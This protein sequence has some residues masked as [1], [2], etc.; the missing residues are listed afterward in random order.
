MSQLRRIRCPRPDFTAS[1][2]AGLPLGRDAPSFNPAVEVFQTGNCYT[3]A[4]AHKGKKR[5]P[6]QMKSRDAWDYDHFLTLDLAQLTPREYLG[7]IVPEFDKHVRAGARHDGLIEIGVNPALSEIPRG[8]NLVALEIV[9]GDGQG[10][11]KLDYHWSRQDSNGLFSGKDGQW[12]WVTNVDHAGTPVTDPRNA[13]WR[14]NVKFSSF[15][16]VPKR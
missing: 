7:S 5:N 12:G 16:L 15:F 2:H 6:G 9:Y 4:L 3:Y 11:R 13:Q 8:Q 1:V 14:Q 10:K